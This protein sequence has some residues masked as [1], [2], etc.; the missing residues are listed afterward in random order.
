MRDGWV[1]TTLGEISKCAG[2]CAFPDAFQGNK[3]GIPFIKVSD[4]NSRENEKYINDANNFVGVEVVDDLRLRIWDKGTVI[5]PKVGAAL[6]TEKR[7]ILAT[8]TIFDNNIMGLVPNERVL[9]EFLFLLML[10]IRFSDYVQQGAVPSIKNSIVEAITVLTPPLDEQKRII[11]LISSIDSY[12]EALRQQL[13]SA[14]RSRNA[15]LHE[16]LSSGGDDWV[17]HKLIDMFEIYQP[18]TI[19]KSLMSNDGEFIVFGANGPIGRYHEFNHEEPEVVVTCRGATCG[20]INMTPPKT[21]I[22]G[23]AMVVSPKT[24]GV[25]KDFLYWAL[26]AG[27]DIQSVISGSAQPQITREGLAPVKIKIPPLSR[28]EEIVD[29]ISGFELTISHLEGS[30]NK[31]KTLRSGLL[32]DLLSGEHE[33]P[34][35]YDKVIGAA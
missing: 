28:Q 30:L 26:V 34:A 3:E 10:Q 8:K 4:M 32:S 16:L 23:N 25:S 5:F 12:I 1:E 15:V 11:D 17:E 18:Q 14:M 35:S 7:R 24:S 21:W 27:V 22:T 2:G 33:I 9:S 6:L 29:L 20:T 19:A 13:D 31:T